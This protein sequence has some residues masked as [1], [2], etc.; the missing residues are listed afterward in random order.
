MASSGAS[1]VL[2]TSVPTTSVRTVNPVVH[3][4]YVQSR[5]QQVSNT[6]TYAMRAP[7]AGTPYTEEEVVVQ[8]VPAGVTAA[9]NPVAFAVAAAVSAMFG[10]LAMHVFGRKATPETQPI[11]AMSMTGARGRS[12]VNEP[13]NAY[14][15][16][17]QSTVMHA[18][19]GG[20]GGAGGGKVAG[21]IKL[22]LPAGKA[23]AAPPVGPALGQYGLNIVGFCK[24]YNARTEKDAAEGLIIP[25]EITAFE[26][27]TFTFILKT[28]PASVLL[29]KYAKI[30][31]GSANGVTENV[32]SIT[33]A[34]LEEIAK[35]K[36]PDLNTNN[37]EAAMAIVKG[38][39]TN[40]GITIEG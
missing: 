2:M 7:S 18:A 35:I 25:V 13:Q 10:A 37:V 12:M 1:T 22:A 17:A 5:A 14:T 29:K 6:R 19:K 16:R 32:G 26:D 15:G 23:T 24:E 11:A 21:M 40:M 3:S 9:S 38:T 8:S 4:S 39:A 20:K 33:S 36:I 34:Q 27:R 31:K 30:D 28:P